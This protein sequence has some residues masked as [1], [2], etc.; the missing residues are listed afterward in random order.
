MVYSII[1]KISV[2]LIIYIF[3]NIFKLLKLVVISFLYE[4]V[5]FLYI[6]G[7]YFIIGVNSFFLCIIFIY[8]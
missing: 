6:M 7:F 1:M 3:I 5:I 4:N 8:K 2:I